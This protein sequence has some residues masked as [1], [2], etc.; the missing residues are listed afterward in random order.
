LGGVDDFWSA[1]RDF[2]RILNEKMTGQ[3]FDIDAPGMKAEAESL[4]KALS[5]GRNA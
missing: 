4:L 2:I 3:K 1:L 5:K